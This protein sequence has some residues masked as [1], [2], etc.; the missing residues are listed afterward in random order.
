MYYLK[1]TSQYCSIIFCS[2][3]INHASYHHKVFIF[4]N[5]NSKLK[6]RDVI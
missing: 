5:G 3:K 2:H 4:K 1:N 6:A